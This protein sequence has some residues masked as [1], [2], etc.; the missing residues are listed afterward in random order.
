MTLDEMKDE[1]KPGD[2]FTRGIVSVRFS[3]AG[4]TLRIGET[5]VRCWIGCMWDDVAAAMAIKIN[6]EIEAASTV[7]QGEL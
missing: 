3:H 4:P 7:R 1:F 2:V 6:E 5:V